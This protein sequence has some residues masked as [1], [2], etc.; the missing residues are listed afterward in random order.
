[1]KQAIGWMIPTVVAAL[2]GWAVIDW[3][4]GYRAYTVQPRVAGLDNRP[5]AAPA[6]EE[7]GD[8][9]GTLKTFDGM[10]SAITASWPGFRGPNRNGILEDTTVPLAEQ[11]PVEG[12]AK[13]WEISLGEGYAGAAVH[14]GCVYV[15]DYDMEAQADAIRCLSLDDG[16]E[17]W[18]YSYPVRIKRNHGMSRTVPAVNDDYVVTIGPKCHVVCLNAKT[19]KFLWMIDLVK[20]YGTKEPLWY[21]GQ[22]PLMV[23]NTA[24]IA[25][26]GPKTLMMAVDCATG[27]VLWQAPSP[28]RW[29]MTHTSILPM[30]FGQTEAYVY[31]ATDGIAGV[32]AT[33]GKPI[34]QTDVW[35]LRIGVASPIDVGSGKIFVSGGY[36]KGAMMLQVEEQGDIFVPKAIFAL[37]PEVFG[38]DQQTPIY[39]KGVI[40]GVRPDKQLVCMDLNGAIRWVSGSENKYGLGPYIIAN[41]LI[42]IL[43]DDGLLSLIR[44]NPDRFEPLGKAKVLSGHESWGPPALASGR[45]IVRDLTTMVCLDVSAK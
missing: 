7:S 36:N 34:W 41:N 21:A 42:Y 23:N 16:R 13:L 3:I 6:P 45:L 10:P 32:S 14:N 11:W 33:D 2:A 15:I 4:Q 1:M 40:Y 12:P 37:K 30:S 31:A 27:N 5:Q 39:H 25:P 44:A 9:T 43:D 22:C 8:L 18:R 28:G 35:K 19:G 17:I 26:A 38:A 29:Q 24:I 20:D